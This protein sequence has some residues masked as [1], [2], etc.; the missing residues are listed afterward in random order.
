MPQEYAGGGYDSPQAIS[1]A[2]II[3]LLFNPKDL[4]SAAFLLSFGAVSSITL[5][6]PVYLRQLE[7][8][9]L[10]PVIS[11]LTVTLVTTPVIIYFYNDTSLYTFLLNLIVIPLMT[12]YLL[13]V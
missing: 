3:I 6:A 2:G 8:V 1:A 7:C 13:P 9:R 10:K 11:S 4:F 12:L 5:L